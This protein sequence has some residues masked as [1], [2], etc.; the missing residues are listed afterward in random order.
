VRG[1]LVRSRLPLEDVFWAVGILQPAVR[2]FL[3]RSV[4]QRE[5]R[6]R[7][8][9]RTVLLQRV[10]ARCGDVV[11]SARWCMCLVYVLWACRLLTANRAP[12]RGAGA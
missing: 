6:R 11:R 7:D 1:F 5:K 8:E 2:G 9:L 10:S 3:A 12:V 4:V